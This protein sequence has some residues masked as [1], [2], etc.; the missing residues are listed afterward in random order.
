[1][2]SLGF[3]PHLGIPNDFGE[4]LESRGKNGKGDFG[5]YTLNMNAL[6][7]TRGAHFTYKF[8]KKRKEVVSMIGKKLGYGMFVFFIT[9]SLSLAAFGGESIP[10][11]RFSF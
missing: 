5:Y 1:V 8:I 11:K 9:L 4:S 2:D 3:E 7:Y 10:Q 6:T